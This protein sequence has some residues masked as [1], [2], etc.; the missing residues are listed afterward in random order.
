MV[1]GSLGFMSAKVIQK[2][3]YI[4]KTGK[5]FF[6]PEYQYESL[7][8]A[9]LGSN[10]SDQDSTD[11]ISLSIKEGN[12]SIRF[13][14]GKTDNVKTFIPKVDNYVTLKVYSEI[15]DSIII[16][17]DFVNLHLENQSKYISLLG[18]KPDSILTDESIVEESSSGNEFAPNAKNKGTDADLT[19]IT[20]LKTYLSYLSNVQPCKKQ[21]L[22]DVLFIKTN[23]CIAY[24]IKDFRLDSL[25]AKTKSKIITQQLK[26][27]LSYNAPIYVSTLP[28]QI[29]NKDV[30]SFNVKVFDKNKEIQTAAYNYYIKGGFKIDFSTGIDFHTLS[31]IILSIRDITD[32][33]GTKYK[34]IVSE[35]SNFLTPGACVLAHFYSRKPAFFNCAFTTGFDVATDSKLKYLAGV[36]FIWGR[37]QRFISSTGFILGQTKTVSSKYRL[38]KP[39]L[40]TDFGD[41]TVNQ[42]TIDKY[43]LGFFLSLSYNLGK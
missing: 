42:L 16:T 11:L 32:N 28:K 7:K 41:L 19:L 18:V 21:W 29:E 31:D 34:M 13:F 3:Y 2:V 26:A 1:F 35:P 40:S 39:Y 30:L 15:G 24:T 22:Y 27:I 6:I 5:Y 8:Y 17:S 9:P 37:E 20:E 36:S 33:D 38:Y 10:E 4:T 25:E 14:K 12:S 43:N 23:I